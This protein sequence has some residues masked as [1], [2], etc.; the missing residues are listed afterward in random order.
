M[1]VLGQ[2]LMNRGAAPWVQAV[3]SIVAIG[4]SVWLVHRAHRLEEPIVSVK[5][6]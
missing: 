2:F 5:K 3:G 6:N 1:G 4:A